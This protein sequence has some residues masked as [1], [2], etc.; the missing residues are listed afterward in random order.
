MKPG[1]TEKQRGPL[2]VLPCGCANLR[3]AARAVTR[4]YDQELRRIGLEPTQYSILMALQIKGQ[5]TQGALG[6][7]LALDS[8]SLTRMLALL[9][10]RGWVVART[11]PDRRQRLLRLTVAGRRKLREAGEPWRRAQEKLRG[12]LGEAVWNQMGQLLTEV[13]RAALE[14]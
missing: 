11:G 8:T 12:K 2:P 4:L 13:T 3:R 5:A 10:K 7:V 14:M 6:A 9:T 1:M